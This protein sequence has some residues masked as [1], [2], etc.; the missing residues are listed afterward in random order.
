M[1]EDQ[2]LFSLAEVCDL[3]RLGRTTIY[4]EINSGRLKIVKVGRRTLISREALR[5]WRERIEADTAQPEPDK[6]A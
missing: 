3:T 4:S 1:T 6:A 2:M 5:D